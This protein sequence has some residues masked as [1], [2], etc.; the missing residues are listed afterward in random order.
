MPVPEFYFINTPHTNT[1]KAHRF[2][3]HETVRFREF[4][5]K[6]FGTHISDQ[7]LS[8]AIKVYNQ[9]RILLKKVYDLRRRD[10]PLISG[11]EALEIVLSSMLIPKHEHNRLLNQLLREAPVRS[12]PPKSGVRLLISGSV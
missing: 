6:I 2:F 1:D 10:P 4:L 3:Y 7:S 11:V 9:N 8:R 12:D 5:E